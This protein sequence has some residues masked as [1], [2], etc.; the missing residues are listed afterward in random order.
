MIFASTCIHFLQP[1]NV[2]WFQE[3]EYS[4]T[5]VYIKMLFLESHKEFELYNWKPEKSNALEA[6][7]DTRNTN[8]KSTVKE[9]RNVYIYKTSWLKKGKKNIKKKVEEVNIP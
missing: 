7:Q 6:E 8:V 4:Q 9:K 3:F 5:D 2:V 1:P